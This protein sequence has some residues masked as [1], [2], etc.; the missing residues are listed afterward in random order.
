M[1]NTNWK[2]Q[3]TNYIAKDYFMLNAI[4]GGKMKAKMK[5]MLTAA[6]F[7][8]TSVFVIIPM[9]DSYSAD[10]G[11]TVE[12][13]QGTSFTY[14]AP[15]GKVMTIG[16]GLTAT[17]IEMGYLNKILVCDSYSN[18]ATEDIFTD[19]KPLVVNSTILAGGNIY[20]SGKS[21]LINDIV[22]ATENSGFDKEKDTIFITGGPSY[23]NSIVD[24]LRNPSKGFKKVLAWESIETYDEMVDYVNVVSKVISGSTEGKAEQMAY[25]A[26][27]IKNTLGD[28]T[29]AKAFYV[30]YSSSAFRVGNTGSLASSMIIAA[31]GI[32]VTVD[33]EK[34][35]PTYEANITSLIETHGTDTII[36][37]DAGVNETNLNA[38]KALVPT[39]VKIVPMSSLWNNFAPDSM[40]GIWIM[41]SAMY[42]DLFSGDVPTVPDNE[43]SN[44][45]LYVGVAIA[46]IAIIGLVAFVLMR[47]S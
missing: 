37:V 18:T 31:G 10:S 12:D 43:D 26:D 19:L 40:D 20:S 16:K 9:T 35:T 4:Y 44:I 32:S 8:M 23:I 3:H 34:A 13:G 22:Y 1:S 38:L 41:A 27:H 30:N 5:V 29:K 45:W 15:S 39:S 17:V 7:M 36:F 6:L 28:R 25:V 14:D 2:K 33:S 42:P 47:R 24:E 11:F 46:A 21:Q